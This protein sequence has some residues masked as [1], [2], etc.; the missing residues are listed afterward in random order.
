[1]TSGEL[2]VALNFNGDLC[3]APTPEHPCTETIRK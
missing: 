1:M 3:G 2:P